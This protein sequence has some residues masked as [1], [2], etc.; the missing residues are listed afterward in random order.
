MRRIIALVI[1]VSSFLSCQKELQDTS[2]GVDGITF[3]VDSVLTRGSVINSTNISSMVLFCHTAPSVFDETTIANHMYKAE[4]QLINNKWITQ[5]ASGDAI[6]NTEWDGDNYHSFFALAPYDILNY[7]VF[8]TQTAVGTPAFLYTVPVSPIDHKDLLCSS[9]INAIH[10]YLTNKPVSLTFAHTLSKITFSANKTNYEQAGAIVEQVVVKNFSFSNIWNSAIL[11]FKEEPVASGH[12]IGEWDYSTS[13]AKDQN[14][15]TSIANGGISSH[16]LDNTMTNITAVD[17]AVMPIPQ[18]FD[19]NAVMTVVMDITKSVDVGGTITTTTN[20][21]I[22]QFDLATIAPLGWVIGKSYNYK[23]TYNGDGFLPS[24]VEVVMTDWNEEVIDGDVSGTYLDV[25]NIEYETNNSIKIY[26]STN[27]PDNIAWSDNNHG[28]ITHT[29][30]S[31][32]LL[33]TPDAVGI[34]NIKITAGNLSRTVNLTS[35]G[36]DPST[37]TPAPFMGNTYVGAFWKAADTHERIIDMN[38]EN[39][40]SWTAKVVWIDDRWNIGDIVLDTNYPTVFPIDDNIAPA[41]LTSTLSSVSG[42]GDIKFR[43]GLNSAYTPTINHPVRYALVLVESDA[44]KQFIYLRQGENPD[45]L[46]RQGDKDGNGVDIVN[47]RG[48]ARKVSAYNLTAADLKDGTATG[49]TSATNN[50]QHP[51]LAATESAVFVDYPTQAGSY[52]QH[53]LPSTGANFTNYAR[54]AYHP[55]NSVGA[56]SSW[57]GSI[58]TNQFWNTLQASQEVSPISYSINGLS[59]NFGRINDGT[60]SG[61]S[62]GDIAGSETRQSLWLNPNSGFANAGNPNNSNNDNLVYGYYADGYFDRKLIVDSDTGYAKSAVEAGA[63][64]VAYIGYIFFN[65]STYASIF[66]PACG[67]RLYNSGAVFGAGSGGGYWTSATRDLVNGYCFYPNT[68]TTTGVSTAGQYAAARTYGFAI[69]P[70]V[71]EP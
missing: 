27:D 68:S 54:R 50:A 10:Y 34:D 22:K 44:N 65:P 17:G 11:T 24:S 12:Y 20:E 57:L 67:F 60:I 9:H 45:Y 40:T 53:M 18:G 63:N 23:F 31:D 42:T 25:A 33:Y 62:A 21:Y 16:I 55:T 5:P 26:Y 38:Q 66:L 69:R 58:S 37:V 43:I 15:I 3:S 13:G 51:K 1:F 49:G 47:L 4:S 2:L 39:I 7:G 61:N 36:I 29:A 41:N 8:S 71:P 14:M 35:S 46:M 64:N 30:G 28:T 59:Y 32:Y 48:S 52:W 56:I 70:I 6:S 19:P